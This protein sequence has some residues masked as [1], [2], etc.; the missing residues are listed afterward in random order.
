MCERRSHQAAERGTNYGPP[1][2]IPENGIKLLHP[3]MEGTGEIWR[4]HAGVP[5]CEL[6]CLAAL[7][8]TFQTVQV[9]QDAGVNH[10][11]SL[12]ETPDF[13]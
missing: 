10:F 13:G 3:F 8:G 11:F 1:G 6:A 7:A 4:E 12:V 9:D 2:Q 5:L